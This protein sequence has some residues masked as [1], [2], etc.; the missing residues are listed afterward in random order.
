MF[1]KLII[2]LTEKKLS[3]ENKKEELGNV[4][5]DASW[6]F[7]EKKS[8]I[9]GF[10]NKNIKNTIDKIIDYFEKLYDDFYN[11]QEILYNFIWY[12]SDGRILGYIMSVIITLVLLLLTDIMVMIAGIPPVTLLLS[13]IPVSLIPIDIITTIIIFISKRFNRLY[14]NK[15]NKMKKEYGVKNTKELVEKYKAQKSQEQVKK[16]TIQKEIK[17]QDQKEVKKEISISKNAELTDSTFLEQML[18]YVSYS[19]YVREED[20]KNFLDEINNI[21]NK[22]AQLKKDN[23]NIQVNRYLRN[24][25]EHLQNEYSRYI[26]N[27]EK[28]NNNEDG[29]SMGLRK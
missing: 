22:Y 21:L 6:F 19:R 9:K 16:H 10:Y 27:Q 23:Q 17:I 25:V 2:Y 20:R 13:L 11:A 8:D 7:Y 24:D 14:N 4:M 12:R 26:S 15:L 28:K 3:I 1:D 5:D 18:G 29:Y